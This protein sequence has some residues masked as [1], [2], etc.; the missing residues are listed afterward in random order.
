MN[1]IIKKLPAMAEARE[2]ENQEFRIFLKG[3]D[4]VKVDKI[5]QQLYQEYSTEYDCTDCGN[6]CRKLTLTISH[7]EIRKIARELNLGEE[8]FKDKFIEREMAEGDRK[9]TRLNSSHVRISY[10]VFCLKK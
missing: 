5:V 2:K 6:C 8:E 3:C 10:A 9:S 4:P 1:S 7:E